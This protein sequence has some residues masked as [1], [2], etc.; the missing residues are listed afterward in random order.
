MTV[1]IYSVWW[2]ISITHEHNHSV[3]STYL[4]YS[5]S[6]KGLAFYKQTA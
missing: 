1:Q 4:S 6:E 2:C 3:F 5:L